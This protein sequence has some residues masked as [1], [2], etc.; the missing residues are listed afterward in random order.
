MNRNNDVAELFLQLLSLY[1]IQ[2]D[3]NNTDLMQELQHQDRNYLQ[4]ILK[5]QEEIL[6]LLKEGSEK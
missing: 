3:F 2:K 5:N 1:I 4:K 6:Q